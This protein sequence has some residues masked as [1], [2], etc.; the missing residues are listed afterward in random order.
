MRQVLVQ[1]KEL[2]LRRCVKMA[3]HK[4]SFKATENMAKAVGRDLPI[5]Y[6][7]ASEVC[8]FIR[9]KSVSRALIELEAVKRKELAVPY[10]RYHANVGH[11]PSGYP[12]RY[13][14]KCASEILD[15]LNSVTA[16]AQSKGMAT[17][18]LRIIHIC[19]HKAAS[20]LRSG[21][22]RGREM[23][24]TH[25]EVVVDESMKEKTA[26]SKQGLKN[27]SN[28]AKE[29]KNQKENPKEKNKQ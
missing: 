25:V 3:E 19:S 10:I 28:I 12:G 8:R 15:L 29:D 20:Q 5:S 23:K 9:G 17:G 2:R 16:N 21:R 26:R 7:T 6:K 4:Y 27:K 22:H 1:Q 18:K 13:P 11:R 24:K 14:Y